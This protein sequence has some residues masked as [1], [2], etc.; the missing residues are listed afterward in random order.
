MSK[1]VK[2]IGI[3]AVVFGTADELLDLGKQRRELRIK[4]FEHLENVEYLYPE[5]GEK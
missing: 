3:L 1:P 5:V 2:S 4:R